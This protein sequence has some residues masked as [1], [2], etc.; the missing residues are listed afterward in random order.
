MAWF[1]K[2]GQ[3][4]EKL[5][6][7]VTVNVNNPS[8][9]IT[10][11]SSKKVVY[12]DLSKTVNLNLEKVKEEEVESVKEV[13]RQAF[14]EGVIFLGKEEK[15]IVEDIKKEEKSPGTKEVLE[16]LKGKVSSDDLSIWRA[17]LYLRASHEKNAKANVKVLKFQII[18]KYGKKGANIAN[19][20]TA[21]Y[22]E[23]ALIPTYEDL[24]KSCGEREALEAFQKIYSGF[25]KELPNTIFVCQ[26]M[27]EEELVE[28]ISRRKRYGVYFI[29]IHG[30]GKDNIDKI[31]RA[32]SAI[33]P[34]EVLPK[35]INQEG[36]VMVMKI[37][38]KSP[39]PY[40][41]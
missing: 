1:D 7:K 24:K 4:F 30:M 27:S 8:I 26:K 40:L 35:R 3:L 2:L 15:E 14:E 23:T 21:G 16:F 37:T 38:F 6:P 10:N 29:N 32:I 28:K 18:Q 34:E 33:D 39:D 25:V 5:A 12:E 22:L 31:N 19:L 9:N 17:A 36:N 13:C 41:S 11:D 20:C